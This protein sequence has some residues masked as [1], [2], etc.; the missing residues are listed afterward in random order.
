MNEDEFSQLFDTVKHNFE[1]VAQSDI[2]KIKVQLREWLNIEFDSIY[3]SMIDMGEIRP[4][5]QETVI[6]LYN[7]NEVSKRFFYTSYIDNEHTKLI[8]TPFYTSEDNEE[9]E[10]EAASLL[11][12]SAVNLMAP[13]YNQQ[14]LFQFAATP[15]ANI[16]ESPEG[17]MQRILKHNAPPDPNQPVAERTRRGTKRRSALAAAEKFVVLSALTATFKGP[18]PKKDKKEPRE[19]PPLGISI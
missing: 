15:L 16:R 11:F 17:V 3:I 7:N 18:P 1:G 8:V 13:V 10:D 2:D 5:H 19:S 12:H 14:E 6:R 4:E 9:S